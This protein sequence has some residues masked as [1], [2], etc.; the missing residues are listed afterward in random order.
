VF[1][2]VC[3]NTATSKLIYDWISGYE[4]TEGEGG[5]KTTRVVKGA[6]RLFSNVNDDNRWLPR[7][8]TLLIDSEQLESGEALSN[9][10]RKLAAGEIDEFKRELRLRNDPRDPDELTDADILREVMNTVGR[11]DRLGADIRCVVSVSMLTEG[12]DANTVTHIMGVRA[13]GTQLLCEQV[14]GRGLRRVSYEVDPNTGFFPVEYADVLGVPFSFAQQGATTAP[15]PPP[16]VTRVR[17]MDDRGEREIR[18]PN[19]EG[20]RVV[21]PRKPLRPVFTADSRLVLTPDDIP[22]VTQSEPIIGEPITF[23]LREDADKLRLKSVI[24]DV[25]GLLLRQRFK[26]ENLQPKVPQTACCR[27]ST[28]TIRKGPP[29]MSISPHQSKHSSRPGRTNAISTTLFMIAT[30]KPALPSALNKCPKS[31]PT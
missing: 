5:N 24:F 4:I 2:V 26:D 21:Y 25:A 16:R 18:F 10:F 20:Y 19:V 23:D 15:K 29:D 17:A 27:F 8:R 9:D 22:M 28:P 30:G 13:F 12:W 6:L 31:S 7:F 3:N 14:V 1:I 11:P